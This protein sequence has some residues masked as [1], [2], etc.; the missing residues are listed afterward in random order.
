MGIL[1]VTFFGE[2]ILLNIAVNTKGAELFKVM[3][4]AC[5]PVPEKASDPMS[6]IFGKFTLLKFIQLLNAFML[7]TVASGK[8]TIVCYVPY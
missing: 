2:C 5:V 4:S 1:T 7:I 8:S 6:N 3:V